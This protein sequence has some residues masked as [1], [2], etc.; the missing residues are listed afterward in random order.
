MLVVVVVNMD[1]EFIGSG[2]F[3]GAE[4]MDVTLNN[5]IPMTRQIMLVE[6]VRSK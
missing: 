5:N 4:N 2:W 1:V 6:I 3:V